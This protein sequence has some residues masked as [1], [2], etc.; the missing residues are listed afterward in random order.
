MSDKP[1][2]D[3]A[4]ALIAAARNR[5]GGDQEPNAGDFLAGAKAM[6]LP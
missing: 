2:R 3:E 6:M 1:D 4:S 5:N